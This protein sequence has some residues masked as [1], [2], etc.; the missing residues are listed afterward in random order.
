[1][2]NL[3]KMQWV[4]NNVKGET[5]ANDTGITKTSIHNYKNAKS[6]LERIPFE[7]AEKLISYYDRIQ[8]VNM[9]LEDPLGF[10]N[11]TMRLSLWFNEAIEDQQDSYN[12]DEGYEDDLKVAAVI[13]T[14]SDE[15]LK[16]L[17][18]LDKLYKV[19]QK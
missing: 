19:Y 5:I 12:S 14:L 10:K 11:F 3:E 17:T 2:T 15:V 13:E 9:V 18:L 7:N 6:R 1:M 4:I 8:D 16:D